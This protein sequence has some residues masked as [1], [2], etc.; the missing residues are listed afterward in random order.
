M[1]VER[2]VEKMWYKWIKVYLELPAVWNFEWFKFEYFLS[3]WMVSKQDFEKNPNLEKQSYS[4]KEMCTLL[5]AMNRYM[6]ALGVEVDNNVDY[7]NT[8]KVWETKRY[9]SAAWDC[10]KSILDLDDW[11]WLKDKYRKM[12][13][14]FRV[15]WICHN[16]DFFGSA[17]FFDRFNSDG[18]TTANLLLKLS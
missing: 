12:G 3:Y 17:C 16:S 6:K 10:L 15:K 2:N 8:L 18:V 14:S 13:D 9:R 5:S 7:E 4:M 1:R 11:Y